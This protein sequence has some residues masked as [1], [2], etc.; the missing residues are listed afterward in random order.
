MSRGTVARLSPAATRST[1]PLTTAE[2]AG[3]AVDLLIR[4]SHGVDSGGEQTCEPIHRRCRSLPERARIRNSNRSWIFSRP[5]SDVRV[6]RAASAEGDI[7]RVSVQ[8]SWYRRFSGSRSRWVGRA[9]GDPPGRVLLDDLAYPV[10]LGLEP[11]WG[12]REELDEEDPHVG[13]PTSRRGRRP[14]L[15]AVRRIGKLAAGS[16]EKPRPR[17]SAWQIGHDGILRTRQRPRGETLHGLDP[18][19]RTR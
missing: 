14:G 11:P 19:R 16:Q 6:D 9:G 8:R 4:P 17:K 18:L 1:T 7:P 13:I 10:G 15:A 5:R 2:R 12:G 3:Q